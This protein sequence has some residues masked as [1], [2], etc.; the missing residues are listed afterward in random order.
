MMALVA[1]TIAP[2]GVGVQSMSVMLTLGVSLMAQDRS[3]PF[4]NAGA[5]TLE[6]LS[7]VLTA[8]TI[9][10]STA[11][12]AG[13]GVSPSVRVSTT[14]WVLLQAVALVLYLVW[15]L[16][17]AHIWG[18][19]PAAAAPVPAQTAVELPDKPA[20]APAAVTTPVPVAP[21]PAP[22]SGSGAPET[23]A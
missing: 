2:C 8:V 4:H 13:E 3:S 20:A 5:N 12:E 7:M 23:W 1:H 14:W 22:A 9:T 10:G 16:L 19:A 18:P 17:A 15:L 6:S 21:A 11:L